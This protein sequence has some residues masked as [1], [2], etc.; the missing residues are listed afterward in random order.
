MVAPQQAFQTAHGDPR[1]L[2]T[3]QLDL[4]QRD[5]AKTAQRRFETSLKRLKCATSGRSL[6]IDQ[7]ELEQIFSANLY[8]SGGWTRRRSS[9][10][11][12]GEIEWVKI[13]IIG[14][15]VSTRPRRHTIPADAVAVPRPS[16][17]PEI[18]KHPNEATAPARFGAGLR[19][20]GT[21]KGKSPSPLTDALFGQCTPRLCIDGT[22]ERI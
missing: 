8:R 6:T 2:L 12:P 21:Q 3:A 4:Q 10:L 14:S 7:I 18:D 20:V 17:S 22:S 19:S 5:P 9:R 15:S 1:R 11:L 16:L 13:R